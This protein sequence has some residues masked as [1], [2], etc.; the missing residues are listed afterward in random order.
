MASGNK[1]FLACDND[2]KYVYIVGWYNKADIQ[3]PSWN[4]GQMEY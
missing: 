4:D 3:K 2:L 1:Y